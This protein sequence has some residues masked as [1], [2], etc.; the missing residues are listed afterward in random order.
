[1]LFDG[2]IIA[3]I[4]VFVAVART[5]SY[6][7]AS[8]LLGLSR[9][10]VGKAIGRL[11]ER[12]GLRLFDR[13]ARA[14]KLTDQGRLFLDEAMPMLEALGRIATPAAPAEIRG[15]LRV[16]T[17]GA[18]GPDVLIPILPDFL[19][20]H[21][22]VRL[23]VLVRDRIDNLLT[24]GFD[25]ALRFG[26]PDA[27]G[28]DKQLL[29]KSRVLTCASR[30]YLARHG[31]P[32]V[33]EDIGE[34][35]RCVRLID[36]VTGRPHAWHFIDAAGE[37]RT[38]APECGLTVNDAASLIAAARCDHG[39]VR[40]LDVVA[41]G[42]LRTGELVEILPEWNCLRWPAYLYTPDDAHR[43]PALEAFMGFVR[44]RLS[45]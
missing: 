34:E 4:T 45:A 33:P 44:R 5:G 8:E 40:L 25:V 36:D 11:E 38:I 10:G 3:G 28:L 29:M 41:E 35:H 17:D 15:R 20:E 26:D 32:M 42:P 1:M 30:G 23:D 39:I 9:S 43:S 22:R 19:A 37:T 24:D 6:A 31:T 16:S 21:P 27:R 14:L 2:R 13:N 18:F 12:T 7:R